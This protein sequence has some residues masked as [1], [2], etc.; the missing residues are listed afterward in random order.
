MESE[1]ESGDV[2]VVAPNGQI[3]TIPKGQLEEAL[4]SG[5]KRVE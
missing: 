3:G 5:Y 1:E 4:K 2:R